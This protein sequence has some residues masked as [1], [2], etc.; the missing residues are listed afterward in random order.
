M[1]MIRGDT[2]GFDNPLS[3]RCLRS[4]LALRFLLE[5]NFQIAECSA[6]GDEV[7]CVLVASDDPIPCFK[8][9][10]GSYQPLDQEFLRRLSKTF[11]QRVRRDPEVLVRLKSCWAGL[12][13]ED[14]KPMFPEPFAWLN[15]EWAKAGKPRGPRFDYAGKMTI[16]SLLFELQAQLGAS[17]R[18]TLHLPVCRIVK[19]LELR[20]DAS[21]L[22][23]R[24]EDQWALKRRGREDRERVQR[25]IARVAELIEDLG[26][27]IGYEGGLASNPKELSALARWAVRQSQDPIARL[28]GER[29]R[30]GRR[31]ARLDREPLP[32]Q[33]NEWVWLPRKPDG[34]VDVKRLNQPSM[35]PT[36]K[37]VRG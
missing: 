1:G 34:T 16:A 28:D 18:E 24:L 9:G 2:F 23:R 35:A 3:I 4:D 5:E 21:A 27:L 33:V 20:H 32:P 12:H 15:K 19:L 37:G 22:R 26:G 8:C 25:K 6:C 13:G 14:A 30:P 10:R 17:K 11:Q 7:S 31:R 36:P 29:I